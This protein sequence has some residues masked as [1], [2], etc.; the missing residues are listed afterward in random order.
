TH[1][2][3]ERNPCRIAMGMRPTAFAANVV[4]FQAGSA[5]SSAWAAP[6]IE[7][8]GEAFGSLAADVRFF[9]DGSILAMSTFLAVNHSPWI[10]RQYRRDFL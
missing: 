3:A 1:R 2:I 6:P 5:I 10:T 9:I 4:C 8:G 7:A